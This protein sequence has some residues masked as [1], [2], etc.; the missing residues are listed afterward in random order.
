MRLAVP[1]ERPEPM[2]AFEATVPAGFRIVEARPVGGWTVRVD[3]STARWRGG[4][5]AHLA[6][7]TFVLEVE[8]NADPGT[9]TLDTRQLYPSGAQVTW[10]ADLTIVPGA[11]ATAGEPSQTVW[12]LTILGVVAASLALGVALV[13]RQ[14]SRARTLRV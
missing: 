4:P 8:V 9:A 2:N 5:L 10:P 14:R 13:A 7:E 12:V 1:N 3:E 6:I 11:A